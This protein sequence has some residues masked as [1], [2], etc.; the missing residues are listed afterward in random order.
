MQCRN[1]CQS[2]QCRVAFNQFMLWKLLTVM[3]FKLLPFLLITRV[4]TNVALA[5]ARG[6]RPLAIFS[7]LFAHE[8][9]EQFRSFTHSQ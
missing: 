8:L 9:I 4:I 2:R 1:S 3:L 7:A 6:T 5:D